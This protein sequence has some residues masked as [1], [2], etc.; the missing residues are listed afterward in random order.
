MNRTAARTTARR[1]IAAIDALERV[2]PQMDSRDQ[3]DAAQLI[4]RMA[5]TA[6]MLDSIADRRPE[7]VWPFGRA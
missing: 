6:I 7:R 3:R 4:N 2:K 5:T 1:L